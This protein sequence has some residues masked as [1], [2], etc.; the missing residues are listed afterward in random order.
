[1]SKTYPSSD[2]SFARLQRSRWSVGEVAAFTP[3]GVVWIVTGQNGE[4]LIE[5]RGATQPEAWHR[6]CEQA[7]AVG[8]L[9]THQD[10]GQT[11][12]F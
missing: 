11:P 5:A 4:N 6:A 9:R 1:M 10:D 7:Q 3:R 8:M 2:E 12:R